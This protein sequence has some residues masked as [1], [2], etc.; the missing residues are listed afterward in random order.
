MDLRIETTSD[1]VIAHSPTTAAALSWRWLR[2]HGDDE[3]SRDPV[4]GQRRVDTFSI[5]AA[6]AGAVAVTDHSLQVTWPDGSRTEID[7]AGLARTCAEAHPPL[8]QAR[9]SL[10]MALPPGAAPWPQGNGD[11]HG[12]DAPAPDPVDRTAFLTD[13]AARAAGVEHLARHGYV[14]LRLAPDEVSPTPVDHGLATAI[15]ERIG[16]VRQTIFGGIWDLAPDLTEHADTS[17]SSV[18]LLPH[19]D[20]TY[21]HDAPGLQFLVCNTAAERGGQSILVDGFAIATDMAHDEPDLAATLA[22][23]A[24]PG[25]YLEPGVHLRAERPP[26]RIDHTGILRQVSF[27]NYDRAPFVLA[28]D[29]EARFY[30][31]YS[32]L[33][34]Q[35]MDRTRWR[36][37]TLHDGDAVVFDNWR[38]LHGRTSFEG[39]RHYVGGYLNHEDFESTRRV[40]ASNVTSSGA[41]H[42]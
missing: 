9:A 33:A 30:A 31:A 15:A 12:D 32:A 25:Q 11:R 13:D 36:T 21:S 19:T 3:A 14:V 39:H 35:V 26:F 20:G 8:R 22:A 42:S 23:V 10:A 16:Y 1:G 24:V 41:T 28:P 38:M 6:A 29:D 18:E 2:D 17:Y 7:L 34:A 37:I 5:D 4:T 27:N 40:L